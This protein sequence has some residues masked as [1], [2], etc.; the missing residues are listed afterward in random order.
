MASV[1]IAREDP[2]R[3][4]VSRLVRDLDTYMAAL[5]PAE[6]NHLL[7]LDTL[8]SDEVVF[9]VARLDG[10]AA[11]CGALWRQG[12]DYGEIKRV[13]VDP[14]MRGHGIARGLLA[15]L[16]I[17]ARTLGLARLRIET[18][19]RQ[20][21]ALGLFKALAFRPCGPFGDYPADDPFSVF[22]EKPLA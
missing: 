10:T 19:T 13:W 16:E 21:E 6:S 8:S 1:T 5:Y 7:D 2:R 4:D 20:P 11:G 15:R 17:E 14:R 22:M 18:G 9:L 3:I 12:A